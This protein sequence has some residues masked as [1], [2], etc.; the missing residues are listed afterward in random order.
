MNSDP[1]EV[2]V[3]VGSGFS[4]SDTVTFNFVLDGLREGTE[5]LVVVL[6]VNETELDPRDQGQVEI[7]NG[8]ALVRILDEDIGK[9]CTCVQD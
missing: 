7:S 4:I 2:S 3:D 1:E 8:V 5:C 6:S 9:Q